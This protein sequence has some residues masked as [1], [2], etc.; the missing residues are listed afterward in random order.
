MK[1]ISKIGNAV[2]SKCSVSV[3]DTI[4]VGEHFWIKDKDFIG[5][6][7]DAEHGHGIALWDIHSPGSVDIGCSLTVRAIKNGYAIVRLNR[8]SVPY[9]APAPIGTVFQIP[10]NVISEWPEMI[11][12][13][14]SHEHNRNALA[15]IYCR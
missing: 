15:K 11:S 2:A 3:G 13:R 4:P 8:P 7:H 9:G 12:E 14:L 6:D 5:Y 1:L 10:L